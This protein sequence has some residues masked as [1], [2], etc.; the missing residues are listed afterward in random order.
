[1]YSI[2]AIGKNQNAL[3]SLLKSGL[4]YVLGIDLLGLFYVPLYKWWFKQDPF[5]PPSDLESFDA[6]GSL[7]RFGPYLS[8]GAIFAT[9]FALPLVQGLEN[10][11]N[12]AG[13]REISWEQGLWRA[14]LNILG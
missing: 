14:C 2:E 5:E 4:G 7:I 8:I 12:W 11:L 6:A 3:Y 9:F 10:Y 13:I 1:G